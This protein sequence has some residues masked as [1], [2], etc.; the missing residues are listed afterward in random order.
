MLKD[1]IR[2]LR[3]KGY[4]YS[5]ISKRTKKSKKY[6]WNV[7]KSIR[8]SKTGAERYKVEV[9]GVVKE[10]RTQKKKLTLAKA[11]IM[12]HLLFDGT[13]F[14]SDYHYSVKYINSS[15]DLIDQFVRDMG[16]V[17]GISPASIE[18]S[19]GINIPWY[20]VGFI[21]KQAYEDLIKYSPSYSTSSKDSIVPVEI[22]TGTRKL[23][24]E[25]LRTFWEDEGSVSN[26]GTL[27]GSSNSKRVMG[28]IAILMKEEG[29]DFG[30]CRS[31]R[32]GQF[33]YKIYLH[34]SLKNL[35]NFYKLGLFERAVVAHGKNIGKKKRDVLREFMGQYKHVK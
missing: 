3:K 16:M 32:N 27:S 34:K 13:V 6:V 8:F 22:M 9:T 30:I 28:Q 33:E 35:K 19:K 23:K 21:S 10:I 1:R 2:E 29:F 20:K 25:F 15:V 7:S 5:E 14:F 24:L 31:M 11:R 17:Y 26:N 18:S 4:S 12:G